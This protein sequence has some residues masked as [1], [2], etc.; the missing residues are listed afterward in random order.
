MEIKETIAKNIKTLRAEKGLTQKQLSEQLGISYK[1]II[2]YENAYREPKTDIIYKLSQ[3][4]DVS[5]AFLRG[6]TDVRDLM[7]WDD[8]EIMNAIKDSLPEQLSD[9]TSHI[10]QQSTDNQKLIF[11]ILVELKSIL[12]INDNKERDLYID[13]VH[14]N[15]VAI[16]SV[17]NRAKKKKPTITK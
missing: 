3:F 13:L 9:L 10:F 8:Q 11:D 2:N 15:I 14:E 12:N 4:F 5:P 7:S 17:R 6:E 16:A 1:S